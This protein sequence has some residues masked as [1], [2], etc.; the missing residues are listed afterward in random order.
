MQ[1]LFFMIVAALCLSAFPQQAESEAASLL[2]TKLYAQID[3]KGEIRAA[4]EKLG[5]RRTRRT[6]IC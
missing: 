5:R 1:I 3:E 2:G 6:L 4:E